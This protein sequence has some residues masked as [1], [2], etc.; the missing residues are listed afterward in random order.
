MATGRS[1]TRRGKPRPSPWSWRCTR[2]S[3]SPGANGRRRSRA[4]SPRARSRAMRTIPIIAAG[5]RP[6]SASSSKGA[7]QAAKCSRRARRPGPARPKPPGT[8]SRFCSP[9]IRNWKLASI[10]VEAPERRAI[11]NRPLEADA[12]RDE[13][14][15][16]VEH[17]LERGHLVG[18]VDRLPE[19]DVVHGAGGAVD[20]DKIAEVAA[21]RADSRRQAL[22]A[23]DEPCFDDVGLAGIED[24][25]RNPNDGRTHEVCLP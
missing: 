22:A 20:P 8:A 25:Q 12:E 7:P 3:F 17:R 18:V 4:R 2:R 15:G 13:F 9:T 24:P 10:L 16:E 19:A 21:E 23:L 6:S 1:S 11:E 5:S 14:R